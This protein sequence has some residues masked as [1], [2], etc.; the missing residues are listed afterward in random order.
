MKIGYQTLDWSAETY[1]EENNNKS[2]NTLLN[3]ILEKI[4]NI[5]SI[6]VSIGIF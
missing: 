6:F 2:K 3:S 5:F 4:M 1:D